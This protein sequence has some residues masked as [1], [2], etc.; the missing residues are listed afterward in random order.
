MSTEDGTDRPA[1]ARPGARAFARYAAQVQ[2][3]LG[4]QVPAASGLGRVRPSSGGQHAALQHLRAQRAWATSTALPVM[5]PS[6]TITR[7]S[8]AA[9]RRLHPQAWRSPT[10]Q[11]G[12]CRQR[13]GGAGMAG[14]HRARNTA[15]LRWTAASSS[16]CRR[17]LHT[18]MSSPD[19]RA[20]NRTRP[21]CCH[22]HLTQQHHVAGQARTRSAPAASAALHWCGS[23]AAGPAS[24]RRC[25][26]RCPPP[27][28]CRPG[29]W[30]TGGLASQKS[31]HAAVHHCQRQAILALQHVDGA[32]GQKV[33]HHLPGHHVAQ[34]GRHALP[35]Q[36]GHGRLRTPAAGAGRASGAGGGAQNQAE[37]QR[38]PTSSRPNAP[39]GLVL[40][41]SA[42]CSAGARRASAMSARRQ[43]QCQGLRR[44]GIRAHA[45]LHATKM[46]AAGAAG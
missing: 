11:G 6:T 9:P 16:P 25:S 40:L 5:K 30:C 45:D 44:K 8:C 46:I 41:S 20:S 19:R 22:A 37:L 28:T 7:R 14:Q 17:R 34:V 32:A 43:R 12:Q 36:E 18:A 24:C 38:L 1:A 13:P 4:V 29:R 15:V 42:A 3:G 39:S 35:G 23:H 31:C 33:L 2:Q 10:A 27:C 26:F 21:R